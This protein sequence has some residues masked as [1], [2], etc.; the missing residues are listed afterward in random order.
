VIKAGDSLMTM[1][2]DIEPDNRGNNHLDDRHLRARASKF[3]GPIAMSDLH[4]TVVSIQDSIG[5]DS[6]HSQ[7][8]WPRRSL[9]YPKSYNPSYTTEWSYG[10]SFKNPNAGEAAKNGLRFNSLKESFSNIGDVGYGVGMFNIAEPGNYRMRFS[11][12]QTNTP[13]LTRAGVVEILGCTD[14]Y[15]AG[16][17]EYLYRETTRLANPLTVDATIT[18]SSAYPYVC[19]TFTAITKDSAAAFTGCDCELAYMEI[20]KI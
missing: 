13:G 3:T 11:L 8:Y 17:V 9:N 12:L 19:P 4:G 7:Q 2:G 16:N 1:I 10:L 6:F 18:V 5:S 14:G 15:I 20:R